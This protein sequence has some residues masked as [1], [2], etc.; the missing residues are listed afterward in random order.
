[1]GR[2]ANAPLTP[3][4]RRRLCERVDAGRPIAHVAAE[5][6]VSRRCL[7]KWYA[8]WQESGP[9]GLA[10]RPSV[11]HYSPNAT[12]PDVVDAIVLLRKE[13]KW[14][15]ARIAAHLSRSGMVVSSATVHRVLRR[16]DMSR[17]RDMDPPTGE[18][19]RT[20]IRY[21]RE[22]AGDL[23]HVDIKKLGRIP[24]GGGWQA[25]GRGSDA[26]RASKRKGAG[27][28]RVGYV[29]LHSA[30][31]DY[32]RLAYTESLPDEK[33]VTA[34]AFWHRAVLFFASHGVHIQRVLTDNG[35][36][37]R[38]RAWAKALA[39]AGAKH[40]KTRPYTP[41]TNGKV[42]RYNGTLSREW[43][44][45]RAYTSE[46]ERTAALA[47]FLNYYNHERP[48]S[49][50]RHQTPASRC[51]GLGPRVEPQPER[52]PEVPENERL[53]QMTLFDV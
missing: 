29:Y 21:E 44:Y 48:H 4:G 26:A 1:M 20:V 34:V 36:C 35:S 18:A 11:P 31:D 15:P 10:D 12:P 16:Q 53:G 30:V 51:P 47:V 6:G 42:E 14:G 27:T 25:H 49:S 38:S 46:A 5:A 45:V 41:R 8:R 22:R 43:A 28:G 3:E 7:A 9:D 2:H 37:Y 52:L 24:D 40:K 23:V 32:S 17:V 33:A 19:L 50:L 39:A 13:Q